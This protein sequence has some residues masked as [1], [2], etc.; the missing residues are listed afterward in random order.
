MDYDDPTRDLT[1]TA[2]LRAAATSSERSHKRAVADIIST[3]EDKA[4]RRGYLIGFACGLAIGRALYWLY[5][6][7]W[8]G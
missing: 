5:V 1:R 6:L 3:L 8:Y 2:E 7:V 4:W